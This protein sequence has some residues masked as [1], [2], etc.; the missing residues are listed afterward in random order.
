M[1]NGKHRRRRGIE[2]RMRCIVQTD[3]NC[4]F[5]ALKRIRITTKNEKEKHNL[6]FLYCS[7]RVERF[8]LSPSIHFIIYVGNLYMRSIITG[9]SLKLVVVVS[10]LFLLCAYFITLHLVVFFFGVLDFFFR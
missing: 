7:I 6:T 2:K 4:C 3:L 8:F 1:R 5:S 10:I 9:C